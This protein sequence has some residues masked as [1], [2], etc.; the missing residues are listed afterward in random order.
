MQNPM[1]CSSA[2]FSTLSGKIANASRAIATIGAR[3]LE[4]RLDRLVPTHQ[5]DRVLEIPFDDFAGRDRPV[6]EL[7]LFAGAAPE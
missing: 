6:P 3:P 2:S 7:A 1:T 4:G 5:R